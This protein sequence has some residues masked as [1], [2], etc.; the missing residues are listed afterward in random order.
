MITPIYQSS[1]QRHW[2][3]LTLTA[4]LL[5]LGGT[6][7]WI[8]I[9]HLSEH[10]V[11]EW[12]TRYATL[13][14]FYDRSRT[15]QPIIK[16]LELSR[17]FADSTTLQA[18][19][20]QP[21]NPALAEA[22]LAEM[23]AFRLRFGDQSYFVALTANQHYYHNNSSNEFADR[24]YRYTLRADNPAD[25]WYFQILAQ[26][27]DIHINV[28]PDIHLGVVKLWLDVLMRDGDKVLGVVGTGLDLKGFIEA[29]LGQTHPGIT[30]LFTNHEGAIQLYRDPALIDYASITKDEMSDKSLIF[31]L[32]SHP[33]DHQR[34]QQAMAAA[35][36]QPG[37]IITSFGQQQQYPLAIA[38]IAELDWFEITIIDLDHVLPPR[39]FHNILLSYMSA[40]LILL[41][42]LHFSLRRQRP[43]ASGQA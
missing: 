27:R 20:H 13:Q 40:S 2:G 12:I 21:D 33:D 1:R 32:F 24:P 26:N 18:W 28:N 4:I 11:E 15:L 36:R 35:R 34:I 42:F 17:Q 5:I 16:E 39:L 6:S 9:R 3:I 22:A 25:S 31:Q 7:S 14:L 38:W 41:L 19:A 29:V 10:I 30:T 23:E 37:T 8:A 43:A